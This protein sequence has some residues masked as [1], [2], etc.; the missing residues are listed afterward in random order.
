M[1]NGSSGKT[2]LWGMAKLSDGKGLMTK[3]GTTL[4]RGMVEVEQLCY[5]DLKKKSLTENAG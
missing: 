1:G 2:S 5:W 4:L 3:S